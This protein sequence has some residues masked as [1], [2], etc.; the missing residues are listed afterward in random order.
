[1][2]LPSDNHQPPGAG[3]DRLIDRLVD[4]EL[5]EAERRA[6]LLRLETNPDGWRRCA[7][8]FLEAQTWREAFGPLAASAPSAARILP[9]APNRQS[10]KR[11]AW[12]PAARLTGLAAGLAASFALGWAWR[13]PPVEPAPHAPGAQG[14]ASAPAAPSPQP[15]PAPI[16]PATREPRPSRPA[17]QPASIETVVKRLE[18]QGYHA[19]TQKRLVSMQLKDGR[20]IDVPVR[21]FRLRYVGGRTF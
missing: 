10:R 14:V 8:A 4:G 3:D 19:E 16:D 12:R 9:T 5:S 1:M 17:E 21:E 20:K 13:G 11:S 18:Q 15:Q 6:L 7:L 2:S